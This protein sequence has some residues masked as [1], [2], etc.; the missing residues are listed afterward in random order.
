MGN[1][2]EDFCLMKGGHLASVGSEATQRYLDE[3]TSRIGP[4]GFVWLGGNDMEQEG[5]WEWTDGTPWEVEFWRPGEPNNNGGAE[6]CLG[7]GQYSGHGRW[8]D[9]KC[10][11]NFVFV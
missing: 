4:P 7:I 8:N 6:N 10:S 9:A 11:G 1:D 3:G 5:V 2:A